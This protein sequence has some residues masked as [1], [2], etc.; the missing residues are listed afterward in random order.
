MAARG[1]KVE[2]PVA[3]PYGSYGYPYAFSEY[4]GPWFGPPVAFGFFGGFES[5]FHHHGSFNHDFHRG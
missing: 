3:W 4:Y 1:N 5:R 2:F